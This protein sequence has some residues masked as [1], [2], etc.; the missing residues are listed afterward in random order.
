LPFDLRTSVWGGWLRRGLR[1]ARMAFGLSEGSEEGSG[2]GEPAPAARRSV[3]PPQ[4]RRSAAENFQ[5]N[6]REK[7]CAA[8]AGVMAGGVGVIVG[9]PFDM[10][11]VRLCV[12]RC[13]PPVPA[14]RLPVSE[15]GRCAAE[16]ACARM[17]VYACMFVCVCA[18]CSAWARQVRM[19][20]ANS[21]NAFASA[22]WD[23]GLK[24][25]SAAGQ[26]GDHPRYARHVD[27]TS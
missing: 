13:A 10:L 11:K 5:G 27:R 17:C 2:G 15:G 16:Q 8:A 18:T 6:H 9:Q 21:Q 22:A 7:F 26:G 1:T 24:G 3:A 20:I 12:C 14:G 4:R 19:Q 25:S 23:E